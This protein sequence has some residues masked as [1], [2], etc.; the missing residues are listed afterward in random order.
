MVDIGLGPLE[1]N[2]AEVFSRLDDVT[3]ETD[4]INSFANLNTS[5]NVLS[6]L[7]EKVKEINNR[8]TVN[9]STTASLT[10]VFNECYY[11]RKF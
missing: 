5:V 11:Q 9:V 1:G 2:S 6:T 4:I 8:S 10:F 3:N 7:S